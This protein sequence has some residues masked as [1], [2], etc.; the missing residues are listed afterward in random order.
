VKEHVSLL[1]EP[2]P[3]YDKPHP[4]LELQM[5]RLICSI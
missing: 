2:H 5:L 3:C 1:A 4:L